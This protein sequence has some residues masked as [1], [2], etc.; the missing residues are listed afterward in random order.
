MTSGLSISTV[1][2]YDH[3]RCEFS[4]GCGHEAENNRLTAGGLQVIGDGGSLF[5]RLNA[6]LEELVLSIG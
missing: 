6:A 4:N 3:I 2:S 5:E 1:R